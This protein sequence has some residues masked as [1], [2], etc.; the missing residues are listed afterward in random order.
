MSLGGVR[1]EPGDL[2]FGDV[3][4][5]LVVPRNVENEVMHRAAVKRSTEAKVMD[6]IA[7]GASSGAAFERYGVL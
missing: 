2:V 6:E 4:G 1:V 5:V 3:D 7:S